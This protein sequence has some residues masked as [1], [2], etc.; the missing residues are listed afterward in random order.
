MPRSYGWWISVNRKAK[1]ISQFV[2]SGGKFES[3]SISDL[4]TILG[5][6]ERGEPSAAEHLLPLVYDEL[7]RLAAAKMAREDPNQTL[8]PTALVHEVWLKLAGSESQ[9]WND[10]GHF[11]AAA[12]EAMRRILID[13]ARRKA[14]LKRGRNQAA[15]ELNESEIEL[16]APTEEILAVHAALDRLAAE[17][18]LAAK[19]VKLRYFVGL[20]IPEI[21]EVLGL[22]P[23]SADRHW[24]FARAW[25]QRTIKKDLAGNA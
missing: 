14:A 15:E 7:R 4:T 20:N 12:A 11:F 23:R 17:D 21:A 9:R 25:L 19:V 2:P 18:L 6:I 3:L 10:R 22:S 24:A 1:I 5:A 16:R 8:Q 13:I